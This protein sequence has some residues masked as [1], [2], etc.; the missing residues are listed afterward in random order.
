[1]NILIILIPIAL[2][3]GSLFLYGFFWANSQG[4]F[5]DLKTPAYKLLNDNKNESGD[6][7]E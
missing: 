3:L 7:N 4:Q 1:M 5:D 6:E 2:G